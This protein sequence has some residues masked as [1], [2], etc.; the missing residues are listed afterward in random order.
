LLR[1]WMHVLGGR[2]LHRWP[3]MAPST[4]YV[5]DVDREFETVARQPG[6]GS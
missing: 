4:R 1:S 5:Y 6:A 2:A 3:Q